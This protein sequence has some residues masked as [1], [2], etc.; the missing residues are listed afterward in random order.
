MLKAFYVSIWVYNLSLSCTKVSILL[1]YLRIF[2]QKRFRVACYTLLGVVVVYSLYT[3][4]TAVFAC[5]PIAFFWDPSLG[6]KCLNRFAIWFANSGINIGTDILT[7]VLPLP[8]LKRLELPR[9]QRRALMI[10]FAL[11]GFTCIVSILRLQSLYVISQSTDVSWDNPLAAIWS[12]VE[13]NTAIICSCLPT[14][15]CIFPRLL[16]PQ[17]SLSGLSRDENSNTNSGRGLPKL[18]PAMKSK[19]VS[20]V[21]ASGP[22]AYQSY[23]GDG[24]GKSDDTSLEELKKSYKS[25]GGGCKN[26]TRQKS[27]CRWNR[28]SFDEIELEIGSERRPFP[29]GIHVTTAIEQAVERK[30]GDDRSRTPEV[31]RKECDAI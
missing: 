15:R 3:F 11:G 12:S 21:S 28:S 20:S 23:R 30:D 5:T 13:A 9:R 18:L 2:I 31:M 25:V 24:D 22:P 17:L 26:H 6:G 27:S 7:A 19:I 16:R 1:Q 29:N 14:L 4:F 10:V 8:M